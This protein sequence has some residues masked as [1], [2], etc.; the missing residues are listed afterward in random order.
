M[1]T[2]HVIAIDQST[3]ASKVFLLDENGEILRRF[4]KNH[5]QFYPKPGHVEHDAGEI[6]QHVREGVAE[7]SQGIETLV[8]LAI[9][10]QRE[11]TVLWNRKTGEPV[12]PAV[13]WQDVRGE[14]LCRALAVHER[15]VRIKT[16]LAL[17]PYFPAAKAASVL[18]EKPAWAR[19]AREGDLC[20][21]TVDSYLTYRLTGRRTFQTDV[22]NASR[23]QLMDLR[24]LA[25]DQGLCDLFGI[26]MGA[27]PK[28]APSD[29]NFGLV[30]VEGLPQGLPIMGVMGDSHAALFGQGCHEKGM[31]KATYG[32]GS[33]VMMN[34]GP[35]PMLSGAGLS[36]SVGYGFQ[37][38]TCYVL[39]GN[40]TC[41]GDTL[42]WLRDELGLIADV[43]E[44]EAL[45][46]TVPD[47]QGVYLV[48]A[49]SG[50]GAPHNDGNA[51]ALLW[52][53][54][55]GTTR[56]HIA[57]A[58]LESMAYQDADI[59]RAMER[60]MGSRLSE[61]RADGGPT[62]NRLLMQ[63]QADLLNCP[64]QCAAASELSA[65]GA[66]YMAGMTLGLYQDRGSLGRGRGGRYV[67][68]RDGLWREAA[69]GGWQAAMK[70]CRQ[71]T[72]V[73]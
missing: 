21:G 62:Q 58:A 7:V 57:R 32:T 17:S 53:M 8:A 40:V 64:V 9:S 34:I 66:G 35:E 68:G 59:I 63:F 49:F 3:S 44:A 29:A 11:T 15:D 27:L 71:G 5:R 46:A 13:V 36:T 28:I 61:L 16:G 43:A 2:K 1:S 42:C 22:S 67:P 69:L 70:R 18:R 12:C 19:M 4:S 30:E 72:F 47:T 65:L 31:A 52:G 14:G 26:P 39:E 55:R 54:N 56:A 41:S 60:D 25:W 48:P 10:N 23:T 73:E 45:A 20:I 24:A 51:R 37:G 6:W 50:L 33:S 38:Q